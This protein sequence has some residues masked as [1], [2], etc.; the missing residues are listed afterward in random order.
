MLKNEV[1]GLMVSFDGL[2]FDDIFFL[3]TLLL[4]DEMLQLCSTRNIPIRY[5]FSG[6]VKFLANIEVKTVTFEDARHKIDVGSGGQMVIHQTSPPSSIDRLSSQP[7]MP[8]C[9]AHKRFSCFET[10]LLI[11]FMKALLHCSTRYFG[12]CAVSEGSRC[13]TASL[14][15]N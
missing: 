9:T 6:A 10:L 2:V 8:I 7:V 13:L 12:R 1:V 4:F 5:F 3:L 11:P 14:I 15:K